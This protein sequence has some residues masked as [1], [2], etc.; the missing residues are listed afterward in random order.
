[1]A[2][3][4]APQSTVSEQCVQTPDNF[5]SVIRAVYGDIAMDLAANHENRQAYAYIPKEVDA[6]KQ[7]WASINNSQNRW[8]WCNPP[9]EN[10]FPW[11]KKAAEESLFG[12]RILMLLPASVGTVWYGKYVMNIAY[13]VY[14]RQ[15]IKFVGHTNTYPKDLMLLI[16]DRRFG[17]GRKQWPWLDFYN[18]MSESDRIIHGNR[19]W[20]IQRAVV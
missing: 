13:E 7:S 18:T 10:I 11:V 9:F 1:M 15:R 3:N 8:L 4:S 12:A 14:L 6:L 20:I 19:P 17:A 16:Y 5:M 2:R